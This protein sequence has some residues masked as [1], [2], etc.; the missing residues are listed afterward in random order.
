MIRVLYIEYLFP[1]RRNG[2]NSSTT[3]HTPFLV[4]A[5]V[6]NCGATSASSNTSYASFKRR[7]SYSR[8]DDRS[9][10]LHEKLSELTI[11]RCRVRLF[12][13]NMEGTFGRVYRGTYTEED[14]VEEEVLVKTVT[15]ENWRLEY[16]YGLSS[17]LTANLLRHLKPKKSNSLFAPLTHPSIQLFNYVIWRNS[18]V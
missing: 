12:S 6:L 3:G 14:G 4:P 1:S 15:G 18:K 11:Q 5:P 2:S 16:V 9:K 8:L 7:P 13:V 10:D 17:V